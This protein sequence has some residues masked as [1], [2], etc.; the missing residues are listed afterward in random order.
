[1][2][3]VC[4]ESGG[5]VHLH[6]QCVRGCERLRAGT[7]ACRWG[8]GLVRIG[9]LGERRGDGGGRREE[10]EGGRCS[11]TLLTKRETMDE[12]TFCSLT[13]VS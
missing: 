3:K 8:R 5:A 9:A 10:W 13:S 12:T 7:T 6:A 2:S 1:M 4:I 11:L